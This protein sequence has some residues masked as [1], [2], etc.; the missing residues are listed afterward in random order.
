MYDPFGST[1]RPQAKQLTLPKGSRKISHYYG[2]LK[3][4]WGETVSA[5]SQGCESAVDGI[6]KENHERVTHRETQTRGL[7]GLSVCYLTRVWI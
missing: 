3:W 5:I 2:K 4:Q 7:K 1:P 6:S